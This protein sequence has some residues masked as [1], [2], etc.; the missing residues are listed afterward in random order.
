M[1]PPPATEKAAEPSAGVA[2]VSPP[3]T[4]DAG[5]GLGSQH[6]GTRL[7]DGWNVAVYVDTCPSA[8]GVTD[9]TGRV[10]LTSA[11]AAGT[12]PAVHLRPWMVMGEMSHGVR[13]RVNIMAPALA[14]TEWVS[15]WTGL[16]FS[17]QSDGVQDHW[18]LQVRLGR[19]VGPMQRD[20]CTPETHCLEFETVYAGHAQSCTRPQ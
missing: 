17:M 4:P 16:A 12:P 7:L 10:V 5:T 11:G 15:R 1:Q 3:Q 20:A 18:Y 6:L 13:T 8:V 9:G 2:P 14:G 19:V